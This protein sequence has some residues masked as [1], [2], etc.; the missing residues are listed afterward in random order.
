MM[1]IDVPLLLQP[2]SSEKPSGE[3]S[4]H[5]SEYQLIASQID[6]LARPDFT[7]KVDWKA[8][9]TQA[10]EIF[11]A[12]SKDFLVAAWIGAAWV[13]LEGLQGVKGGSD[14]LLGMLTQYWDNGF[15][16][17][18]RIRGR[19]NAI[20]WWAEQASA[21]IS[22]GNLQAISQDQY[23][24]LQASVKALDKAFA[25]K[26]AQA[27]S[28]GDFMQLVRSV[29]AMPEA[30]NSEAPAS[31]GEIAAPAAP[32]ADTN[33]ST[34]TAPGEVTSPSNAKDPIALSLLEPISSE[35]P[36]GSDCRDGASYQAIA[37]QIEQLARPEFT[38]T[39]NWGNIQSESSQI[40][41][42]QSKDFMVAGWVASSWV[43]LQGV[44]GIKGG[45]DLFLGM[46][47]QYW[48]NGFPGLARIRGRRNAIAWWIDQVS[49]YIARG[50]LQPI[51]Q[52]LYDS[53]QIA[54]KEL[55]RTFAEKDS[56][57]PSLGDFIQLI[58]ALEVK[59]EL[60]ALAPVASA[61]SVQVQNPSVQGGGLPGPS[62]NLNAS[63]DSID[64]ISAALDSVRPYVGTVSQ[65]LLSL[66]KFN[67]LAISLN[68]FSARSSILELPPANGGAT[69]LPEPPFS[70]LQMFNAVT[71]S[72]DP[73]NMID[74]CEGRIPQYPY[75][76]DLDYFSAQAYEMLGEPAKLM[77]QAVVDEALRFIL[78]LEGVETLSFAGK[79]TPFAS[80]AAQKWLNDCLLQSSGSGGV[81]DSLAL[82]K[83]NALAS[84]QGGKSDEVIK[85]LQ[86]YID[87]TRSPREQFRA[88]IEL[89]TFL[90]GVKKGVDISPL[91]ES[92][93]E[94]CEVRKLADW[95]P[96]LALAAWNLRLRSLQQSLMLDEVKN[97]PN[98]VVRY[99][100][101]LSEALA[102]IAYINYSEAIR[103]M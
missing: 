62:I 77:K 25:E 79:T 51:T 37:S 39:L 72:G 92:L 1:A 15:P 97:D 98:K 34:D 43:E 94:E 56:E 46:L 89:L 70:E 49:N 58:R 61:D 101:G 99:Q 81:V 47:T 36:A 73:D 45:A 86:T 5:S 27:P 68:R 16:S 17:L 44:P 57:A 55:D 28:L 65:A 64:A 6:E 75:W 32:I 76:L 20:V 100:E 66:D 7:G 54:V 69:S 85:S 96:D 80:P 21:Y 63:L 10:T 78:R 67:S 9:E 82:A 13:E 18:E 83:A 31:D 19:R 30:T 42:T 53:L 26:D 91:L 8:I 33:S 38:G 60:V 35:S 23:D 93:V 88:R 59:P 74:F 102:K 87:S 84:G 3:E 11:Q 103:G 71:T 24:A 2:I 52:N 40:L 48:D 12:Q 29:E 22:G 95:D 90:S 50:G 14:L 41:Q 4:N